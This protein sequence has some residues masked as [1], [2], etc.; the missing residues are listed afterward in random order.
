MLQAVWF[1]AG[2]ERGRAAAAD[3]P[4][5]VGRRGVVAHPGAG[6]G[7]G[8]AGDCAAGRSRRCRRGAPRSAAW[9]SGLRRMRGIRS[10]CG[11]LAF[12]TGC[13][14][15]RRC[16]CWTGVLD[17]ARDV[18]GTAGHLHADAAGGADGGAADP[19]AGGVPWRH[20]R[21]AADRPGAW[22]LR[23]GAGGMARRSPVGR[24]AAMRCC[25]IWRAT[26]ARRLFAGPRSVAHG[27]L[28]H[29]PVPGAARSRRG[30]CRGGAG[31]RRGAGP[32]AQEHQGAAAG[33]AEQRARLWPAAL[34]QPRDGAAACR[35]CGAADRLQLS[36]ALVVS[37]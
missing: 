5:F 9:R 7:V 20:Q 26:A 37:R 4:S 31:R 11:E 1:D 15:R 18:A 21:C 23:T 14:A 32:G 35:P 25:W 33:A 13:R 34:P 12:W 27:G 22:L 30:G 19:G 10:W 36:R 8:V 16:R 3:D 24:D 2:A 6:S 17:P 29:Q 28:V